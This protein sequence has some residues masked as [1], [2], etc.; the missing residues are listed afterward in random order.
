[1]KL[2][3]TE[4]H[5]N[6]FLFRTEVTGALVFTG[7]TPSYSQL[8]TALAAQLSVPEQ[9]IAIIH[10]YTKYGTTEAHFTAHVYQTPEHLQKVEPKKK[11]KKT[12]EEAEK[13]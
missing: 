6:P 11:E 12:K 7:A 8:K 13:K 1:M 2:S 9:T 4:K 10:V 3:I 5:E